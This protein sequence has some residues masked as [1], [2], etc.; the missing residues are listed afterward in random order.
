MLQ[1][2]KCHTQH[3]THCTKIKDKRSI[4]YHITIQNVLSWEW[5]T[6]HKSDALPLHYRAT[7]AVSEPKFIILWLDIAVQQ[8]FFLIVDTYLICRDISRQSCAMVHM[9]RIFASWFPVSHV[10]YISDLHIKFAQDHT[11]CES[12]VDIQLGQEKL[13]C[14]L[15]PN[16]MATLPNI[17][18]AL[19]SMP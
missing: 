17:G 3:Q 6:D 15:M 18:G 7:S 19:C 14:G 12:M 9:W 1:N 4:S 5:P 2:Q 11:M 13:E 10:Q 8:V 16:V